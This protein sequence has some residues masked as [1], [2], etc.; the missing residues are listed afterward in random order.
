MPIL[1]NTNQPASLNQLDNLYLGDPNLT[2]DQVDSNLF[3]GN[4]QGQGWVHQQA[5]NLG[6]GDPVAHYNAI[7]LARK[8]A[9]T[10]SG[11][12]AEAQRQAGIYSP[13]SLPAQL[14][15]R[16]HMWDQVATG[17]Q[18]QQQQLASLQQS[19]NDRAYPLP[20]PGTA[21]T[22]TPVMKAA[23]AQQGLTNPTQFLMQQRLGPNQG[24]VNTKPLA[25]A[26]GAIDPDDLFNEPTFQQAL[27][28]DPNKASQ[29]FGALTGQDFAGYAKNYAAS[30]QQER[31][32]GVAFLRKSLEDGTAAMNADGSMSWR[33]QIQNPIS[34]QMGPGPTLGE[35][36]S[37]QKAQEKFLPYLD[38]DPAMKR[39]RMLG[40]KGAPSTPVASLQTPSDNVVPTSLAAGFPST[41]QTVMN[42]VGGAVNDIGNMFSGAPLGAGSA[43]AMA[44]VQNQ[45]PVHARAI[46][47]NNPRFQQLMRTKPD[48][49][50]RIIM[51]IQQGGSLDNSPMAP[52]AA[53][54]YSN[55]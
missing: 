54:D 49:A 47:L 55:P 30:K 27:T 40:K 14:Q 33:A 38:S 5:Q 3:L 36:N 4:S 8:I 42:T 51:S 21:P 44:P 16:D 48:V 34:G 45:A 11:A 39:F 19:N 35:G 25:G 24:M 26:S 2:P 22:L 50:R 17:Q 28:K 1:F 13:T 31:T 20:T 6:I 43:G 15:A 52:T 46:L 18:Q 37:F 7:A 10:Q 41:G 29:V 32:T 12:V 9:G 23:M 53:G